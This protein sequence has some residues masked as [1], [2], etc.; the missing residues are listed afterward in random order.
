MNRKQQEDLSSFRCI[1]CGACCKWEG[2]VRVSDREIDAIADFLGIDLQS[3]IREY[4]RLT[5]DRRSL[6]LLEKEDGSCLYYDDAKRHAGSIPSSRNSAGIFRCA[7]IS[8]PGTPSAPARPLWK[9]KKTP[10]PG[11]GKNLLNFSC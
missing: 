1:R 11:Q 8:P 4:T 3:F 7:G 5:P 2:P 9:T 10:D 6:S